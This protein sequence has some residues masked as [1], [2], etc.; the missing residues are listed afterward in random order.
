MVIEMRERK[1]V[2]KDLHR[3]VCFALFMKD[4]YSGVRTCWSRCNRCTDFYD[5]CRD[6]MDSKWMKNKV[7]CHK[8]GSC[9]LCDVSLPCVSDVTARFTKKKYS[10]RI[11][12]INRRFRG[13][14][15]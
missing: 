9:K 5:A 7:L 15:I 12:R 2:M 11:Q 10:Y 14:P 13:N 3:P 1:S 6:A 8:K 4:G